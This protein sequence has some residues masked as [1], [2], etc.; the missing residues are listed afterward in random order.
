MGS[1]QR[2]PY[3]LWCNTALQKSSVS[4]DGGARQVR[5]DGTDSTSPP[6][7]RDPGT[8]GGLAG[9][10]G[11]VTAAG[12]GHVGRWPVPLLRPGPGSPGKMPSPHPAP[13]HIWD[14][15]LNEP[16]ELPEFCPR[17]GENV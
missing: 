16:A 8:R 2:I 11:P 1:E 10:A 7:L 13:R 5:G 3:G 14:A 17:V 12:A 4:E 9:S 15:P 6:G